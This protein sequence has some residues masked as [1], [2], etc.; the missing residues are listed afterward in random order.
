MLNTIE[1]DSQR[2]HRSLVDYKKDVSYRIEWT[3]HQRRQRAQE[4]EELEKDKE[5]YNQI[6]WHDFVIVETVDY[7]QS[8]SLRV[9]LTP[10]C[11]Y[12]NRGL[13]FFSMHC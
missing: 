2:E 9:C 7:Q 8:E 10:K 1:R 3:R 11:I 4:E 5:H 13:I 12:P 6:D